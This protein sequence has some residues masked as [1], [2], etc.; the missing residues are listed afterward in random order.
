MVFL[1]FFEGM[2]MVSMCS[3]VQTCTFLTASPASLPLDH[4]CL[5][6]GIWDGKGGGGGEQTWRGRKTDSLFLKLQVPV[7]NIF[8]PTTATIEYT[9]GLINLSANG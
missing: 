5:L 8:P 7:Y 1:F 3:Q 9:V 4:L 6:G 2:G